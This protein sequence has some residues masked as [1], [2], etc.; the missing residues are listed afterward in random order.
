MEVAMEI[1]LVALVR[2]PHRVAM[3][4]LEELEQLE[5][6]VDLTITVQ[7]QPILEQP[8]PEAMV[9]V[10]EREEKVEDIV[11]EIMP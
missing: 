11:E 1:I 10:A 4:A 9:E 2:N 3:V 6:Q 7:H 8:V 5:W